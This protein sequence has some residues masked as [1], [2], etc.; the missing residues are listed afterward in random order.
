MKTATSQDFDVMSLEH[1]FSN[2]SSS[3]FLVKDSKKESDY[4]SPSPKNAK[5]GKNYI[6]TIRFIPFLK[7]VSKSI[8]PKW[9]IYLDNAGIEKRYIDCPSTIEKPSILQEVYWKLKNSDNAS[10]KTLAENFSR[11]RVY[12][13]L[14]MIVEDENRPELV[15]KIKIFK[16]GQ[17]LYNKLD[18]L[19]N[20][21]PTKKVKK[22]NLFSPLTARC[23]NLDIKTVSGHN[24]YDDSEFTIEAEPF[25]IDGKEIANKPE[26]YQKVAQWISE[27]SPDLST[28]YYKEWDEDTL[29]FVLQTIEN[30]VPDGKMIE[31]VYKKHNVNKDYKASNSPKRVSHVEED[32][33]EELMSRRKNVYNN[34]KSK[35]SEAYE[36]DGLLDEVESIMKSTKVK[37]TSKKVVVEEEDEDDIYAGL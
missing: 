21:D 6:S 4:Y 30:V 15:G 29:R 25:I 27:N 18:K 10:D 26:N 31:Q 14:V 1:L 35:T 32:E 24:N 28:T 9:V 12:F 17:K 20:P 8:V 37:P 34:I 2:D 36:E 19:M 3:D 5:N 33:D 22:H 16:Y 13:S 11:R 23:L 7:D